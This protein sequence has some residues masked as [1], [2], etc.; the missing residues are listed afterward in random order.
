MSRQYLI[1]SVVLLFLIG[2]AVYWALFRTPDAPPQERVVSSLPD[3]PLNATYRIE[4]QEVTLTA[5][6]ASEPIPGSSSQVETRVFGEPIMGDINKD[7]TEDAVLLFT[8]RTGGSGTF[9][10]VA[11][12]VKD[13]TGFIGS[14]AILLGDRIAL[15][16]VEIRDDVIVVN[17]AQHTQD[18]S[19]ADVPSEAV[20]TYLTLTGAKLMRTDVSGEGV[21]VL[22]GELIY[23][24]ESRTFT[25]CPGETYWIA[26]TS[27]AR[28][29]LQAIYEERVKGKEPYTPVYV[30]VSGVVAPAPTEGFGADYPFSINVTQVLSAPAVG[31]C[32]ARTNSDTP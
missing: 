30:V 6:T 32:V 22:R 1:G 26:S 25:S 8:Q 10:Y 11:V 4:D 19:F 27:R 17:Y 23:G 16:N 29:A 12:A 24:H 21:Q 7:G 13:E 2:T 3:S 15:Q 9:Y 20:S 28:A 18:Q 31:A 5:G 14:N